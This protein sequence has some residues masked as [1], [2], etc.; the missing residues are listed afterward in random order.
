MK[1]VLALLIFGATFSGVA[2]YVAAAHIKP[3]KVG[4]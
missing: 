1:K 2:A 4:R 3:E